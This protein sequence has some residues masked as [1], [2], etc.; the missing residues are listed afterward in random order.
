VPHS[1]DRLARCV[2]LRSSSSP[3]NQPFTHT[4]DA[5]RSLCFFNATGIPNGQR[6]VTTGSSP[7]SHVT[8]QVCWGSTPDAFCCA[9]LPLRPAPLKTSS[10][11]RWQMDRC[12]SLGGNTP[13]LTPTPSYRLHCSESTSPGGRG[14]LLLRVAVLCTAPPIA[15]SSGAGRIENLLTWTRQ[16]GTVINDER[17][18]DGKQQTKFLW[19]F[20]RGHW[21][22]ATTNGQPDACQLSV[23]RCSYTYMC[24]HT[25]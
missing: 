11:V 18:F 10:R 21:I 15:Q 19:Q 7:R 4:S 20:G 5:T 14:L 17:Y 25:S 24:I 13:Q 22:Y 3:L 6:T 23:V 9:G 2:S 1:L 12:L 8:E 16:S